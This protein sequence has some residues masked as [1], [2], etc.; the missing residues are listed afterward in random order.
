MNFYEMMVIFSSNLSDE[1]VRDQSN[2]VEELLK[3]QKAN[4]HLIDRW[5]KRKLAYTIKKQRQGY[6]D[7]FYYQMEPARVAEVDR[8]LKMSE[9]ILRFMILKMEKPQVESMW[10]DIERR[11][12][13]K[14]QQAEAAAA[15]AAAPPPTPPPAPAPEP[16]SVAAVAAAAAPAEEPA[17]AAAPA[18]APA[19][20]ASEAA[21]QQQQQQAAAAAGGEEGTTQTEEETKK[22]TE[23]VPES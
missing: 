14:R 6:Y 20:S 22:G 17:A 8:K 15:A 4:I 19:E 16:A 9:V 11:E 13:S 5:G 23:P 21:Q 10:K 12:E 18:P 7:W 1:E 2:Q 3:A